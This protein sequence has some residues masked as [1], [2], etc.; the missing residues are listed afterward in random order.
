[1]FRF[2]FAI[3]LSVASLQFNLTGSNSPQIIFSKAEA[4]NVIQVGPWHR[5]K[6][7]SKAAKKAA[8][9]DIIEIDARGNY[10][11]DTVVWK[12]NNLVIKGV[13][14]R[15]HIRSNGN[16]KNKKAIWVIRGNDILV[17][18]IEFSGAKV[19]HKNG[20]GIRF[21]GRNLQVRN[22]FFHDN[23]NGVLAGRKK[24]SDILVE[25]SEFSN[26]GHGDGRS[27][28]IYVGRVKSLV[29]KYNHSHHAR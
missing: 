8:D 24:D 18:N 19:P 14:G 17:E 20:A 4:A 16:I 26:N 7:P 3:F 9:G 29:F 1:M 2:L 15:P 6:T 28:N 22:C 27:H 23:E 11:N 10:D 21:E 13:N 5:F 12:A 25:Y